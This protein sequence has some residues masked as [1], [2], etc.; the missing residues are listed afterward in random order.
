MA[1]GGGGAGGAM[2]ELMMSD[3]NQNGPCAAVRGLVAGWHTGT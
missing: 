1:G 2:R 3:R